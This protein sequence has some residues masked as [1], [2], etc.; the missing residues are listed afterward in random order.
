MVSVKIFVEGGGTAT[1]LRTNCRRAFRTLL[2]KAGLKD[3]MPTIVACGSRSE[4]Y[5]DFSAALAQ[6]KVKAV[7]LVDS[8]DAVQVAAPWGHVAD[9][10][11]DKWTRP[12][13]AT[14]EQLHFMVRST[15]A[16]L[17][18]DPAAVAK[19]FDKDFKAGALP[20]GK[21]EAVDRHVAVEA[22]KKASRD[23]KKGEYGKGAHSFELLCLVDPAKIRAA[24]PWAE[25][26]FHAMDELTKA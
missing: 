11:G 24:S 12:A 10:E 25:R 13:G 22:L 23:T 1:D 18:A 8:E 15:E 3:R 20:K 26:F 14:D 4:A 9:R 16:W 21:V 17:L 19:Y 6:K 7:L 5:R 2:E